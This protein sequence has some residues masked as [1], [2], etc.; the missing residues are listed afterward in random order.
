MTRFFLAC[1]LGATLGLFGCDVRMGDVST[2][3]AGIGDASPSDGSAPHDASVA[4]DAPV[5]HDAFAAHDA[6]H[7][8]FVAH[9][10]GH[11]SGHDA[12][13]AHDAGHDAHV[14]HDAYVCPTWSH[15]VQPLLH[16]HCGGCHSTLTP[17]FVASRSTAE[18]HVSAIISAGTRPGPMASRDPL[19]GLS[20]GDD[21]LL[22]TWIS[23]G[24][25]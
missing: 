1:G 10:A 25:H 19:G 17:A 11:D 9:D 5:G 7:D 6:G 22:R 23:C 8:A 16:R 3:D 4:H 21:T 14:G 12:H 2:R 20:H 24:A 13:V 15:D 18:S